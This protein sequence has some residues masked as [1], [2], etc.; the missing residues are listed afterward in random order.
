M[1][2]GT[3]GIN[4][5]ANFAADKSMQHSGVCYRQRC[6]FFPKLFHPGVWGLGCGL[7]RTPVFIRQIQN[8]HV[9]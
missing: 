5:E 3:Y 1:P 9:C 4:A 7:T 2:N 6:D 8:R